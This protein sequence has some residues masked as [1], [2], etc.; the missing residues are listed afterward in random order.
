MRVGRA[1]IGQ[2]SA[3]TF[4][5]LAAAVALAACGGGGGD[6]AAS[7]TAEPAAVQETRVPE[8]LVV[9]RPAMVDTPL[10]AAELPEWPGPA[11]A[12]LLTPDPAGPAPESGTITA[13]EAVTQ[14]WDAAVDNDAVLE[15]GQRPTEVDGGLWAVEG[16]VDWLVLAPQE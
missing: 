10:T 14:V 15:D 1:R 8:A 9:Y 3:V 12:E 6:A 2:R 13:R 5:A 4:G 7:E 16:D 11:P